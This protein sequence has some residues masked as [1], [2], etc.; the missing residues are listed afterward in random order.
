[1]GTD[2][3]GDAAAPADAG[4]PADPGRRGALG[5][6]FSARREAGGAAFVPYLTFGYPSP[7]A[8]PRLLRGLADAGADVIELGVPFSDP[9]ADGPTIQRA[10]WAALEH[11]VTLE[12]AL[13]LLEALSGDLPPVVL[14][15]YLNPVLRM[16]V[17][18]FAE[19]ADRAGA[20]GVLITD[21]PVGTDVEMERRLA[22]AGPELIRLV[23]PTTPD[24]RLAHIAG[25]AS[26]FL[27]Y[28]S[29]TGVT[30]EREEL[31]EGLAEAVAALREKVELPVAVGFGVST[32]EQAAEVAAAAD[33]V[34]VGSALIRALGESE[35]AFLALAAELAEAAHG[36][37]PAG[38]D[39]GDG[40]GAG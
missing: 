4:E 8:T 13:E 2:P 11:G 35:E 10:S 38:R 37:E 1:M 12:G 30:G 31:A 34:V 24:G 5:R 6:A 33:G 9:L 3:P 22:A 32:P 15:S 16:G 21:L 19:R 27:Y 39:G 29:R 28:I 40:S 36:A 14:F 26:G 17:E 7:E 20:A 25:D 18:R 23:A